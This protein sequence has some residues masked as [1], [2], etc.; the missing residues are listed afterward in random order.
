MRICYVTYVLR[1]RDLK[2]VA[3]GYFF[4]YLQ[5]SKNILIKAMKI[6][7]ITFDGGVV[8]KEWVEGGEEDLSGKGGARAS[9]HPYGYGFSG[10]LAILTAPGIGHGSR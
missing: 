3:L 5:V 6:T 4:V 10:G 9:V 8:E 7:R 1:F 2:M